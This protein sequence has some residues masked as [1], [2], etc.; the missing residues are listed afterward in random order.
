MKRWMIRLCLGLVLTLAAAL[1]VLAQTRGA[2][3]PAVA[4]PTPDISDCQSCHAGFDAAWSKGAHGPAAT[5]GFQTVWEAQGQPPACLSCHTQDGLQCQSCHSPVFAE[6]PLSPGSVDR[7]SKTCGECH[8]ATLVGWQ[9][10]QHGQGEMTCVDCHDPHAAGVNMKGG[11]AA[12]LC[13]NCHK[14]ADSNFAH[15][16]HLPVVGLTC[17]E[18]HVTR[19]ATPAEPH[20]M[21]DHSFEVRVETCDACHTAQALAAEP[22]QL[23]SAAPT[24]AMASALDVQ[25]SETP[26]PLGLWPFVA[27]AVVLGFGAGAAT[28]WLRRKFEQRHDDGRAQPRDPWAR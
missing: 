9:V 11:D 27:G 25:A 28:P 10:S 26:A 15:Q 18:C 14:D 17:T 22:A 24:D 12:A 7:G 23:E 19:A 8:A 5:A 3:E 6:H 4:G 13:A 1:P 20:A 21:A 16:A 2:A